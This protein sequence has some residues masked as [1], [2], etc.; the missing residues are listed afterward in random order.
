MIG[1]GVADS[2]R[3]EEYKAGSVVYQRVDYVRDELGRIWQKQEVVWSGG[4][5]QTATTTYTYDHQG[6]LIREV[7]TG[8]NPYTIEYTY[9]LVGNHL[10]RTRTVNGQSFTDTMVYNAANQLESWNGQAWQHDED[11]HVVVRRVGEETWLLGYDA[12]GNLVRLQKQGDSVGWVYEYDG[13]GRQVR[14]VR[15]SLEVVYL[16]SGDTLVAEGSRQSSSEPLQWVYYGFGGSMYSQVNNAGTEYKHWSLRGD[17]VATSSPT[18]TYAPAPITDAFGDWVSGARQIYDWNGLWGYRNELVEAGGL[19]KVGVRWY[20][21][22][23]GRFL[24]QDPWVG[25]S[26][27]ADHM[28]ESLHP[29]L[30]HSPP[31]GPHWE[32]VDPEGRHYRYY[33]DNKLVPKR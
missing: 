30:G 22:T 10:T 13:L 11:G 9:D 5:P 1:Y 18:G 24:Q 16:Y 7:R 15:G 23:V 31:D 8:S 26:L 3:R 4:A 17:L 12:E 21:P 19:V 14:A 6:Q 29:D 25:V 28:D 27:C 20:D 33:P 32:Y 2:A